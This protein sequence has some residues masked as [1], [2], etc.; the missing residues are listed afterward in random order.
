MKKIF[1]CLISIC[2]CLMLVG[3][4]DNSFDN[5]NPE[6]HQHEYSN[7]WY[8]DS[9]YHWKECSCG[10]KDLIADHTFDTYNKCSVCQY[11]FQ[12]T[13]GLSF[14]PIKNGTEYEVTRDIVKFPYAT[15]YILIIPPYYNGKPVTSIGELAFDNCDMRTAQL[16]DTITNIG[17]GAFKY[18]D[19]LRSI[20]IPE[21]C[22]RIEEYAFYCC[23]PLKIDNI[24]D[25]VYEIGQYAFAGCGG[26]TDITLPRNLKIINEGL[27]SGCGGLK[28]ITFPEA[29][30]E[31]K[32]SA[33]S[34]SGLETIELPNT[35]DYIPN[36]CFQYC[37]SLQ[38]IKIPD[39]VTLIG[40]QAFE[41][42]L[43]LRTV[44]LSKNLS[45]ISKEAFKDCNSLTSIIIPE[46]VSYIGASAFLGC[47]TLNSVVFENPYG[48]V[49]EKFYTTVRKL[50]A[51]EI[52]NPSAMAI[53][54]KSYTTNMDYDFVRK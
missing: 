38:R 17:V 11:P 30:T 16:P 1:L 9:E 53:L 19:E 28:N 43:N 10:N 14:L 42:C 52:G 40:F 5:N 27:L 35:I 15:I 23:S 50:E 44:E 48:W 51:T 4:Q 25:S 24:P 2:F 7:S 39:S 45:H 29:L 22:E 3:C 6:K 33:F 13:S 18:C 21:K 34:G 37:R 49:A 31:I 20:N 32:K 54:L 12:Y 47:N 41:L 26:I 8:L 36:Y 46:N